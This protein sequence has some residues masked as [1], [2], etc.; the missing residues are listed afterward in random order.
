MPS[1]PPRSTTG[2]AVVNEH[3]IE[4]AAT[5]L[6]DGG[7]VAFPTETVYGLGCDARNP[8]ALQR[9]YEVKGRPPE[10][11][12]IVHLPSAEALPAW[13]SEVPSA[14][15]TLADA[16]WPGPLTIV[17]LR[18]GHVLDAVTGGRGGVALRVPDQR[19]ALAL[20]TAF[21]DGLAAPSANRFGRVSPTT[22]ADVVADLDG[23]VDLVLDD[24][25][26]RVGVESTIVDCTGD[27]PVILRVGG[28]PQADLEVLLG[29]P[30][31]LQVDGE[32]A[33][34]GTLPFHYSPN[35][36]VVVVDEHSAARQIAV[37][38]ASGKRV[39]V[40]ALDL[41]TGLSPDVVLLQ[42]PTSIED[43]AHVL[44]VRLR[45]ADRLALDVLF[46]VAPPEHGLG[47][48]VADRL[49]RAAGKRAE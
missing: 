28:Y 36:C 9:L 23:D 44:Y 43:F 17:V 10:H 6:H 38:I 19:V 2:N 5:I 12:V 48:A 18:A 45:D 46:A 20:L 42:S 34:P 21:G 24:G 25:P 49:R 15:R 16:C 14:A 8:R 32:R 22:A 39:G 33:A 11:P 35:A 40:L 7:L 29:Q 27:E 1:A 26:C 37:G 3:D 13:T 41:P 31:A 4:Q 30:I 47:A